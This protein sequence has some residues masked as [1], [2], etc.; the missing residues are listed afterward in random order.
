MPTSS[1][2]CIRPKPGQIMNPLTNQ[3][4]SPTWVL[5]WWLELVGLLTAKERF[6]TSV[7]NFASN[8]QVT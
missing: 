7:L 5:T 2:Y 4:I 3:M 8:S 6:L 1:V